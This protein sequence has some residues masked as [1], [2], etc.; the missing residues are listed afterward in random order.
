MD[1]SI[2]TTPGGRPYCRR[3][4]RSARG[5]VLGNQYERVAGKNLLLRWSGVRREH[6]V[7]FGCC[8]L[9][10]WTLSGDGSMTSCMAGQGERQESDLAGKN[11]RPN[12]V[13][14]TSEDNGPQLAC[15]GDP[16][17]VTPN[18]D[19]LAT[20]SIRFTRC[21]SNAPVCAPARTTLITGVWPT[22]LGASHMRSEVPL[23]EMMQLF[24]QYLRHAGYYCTN[25]QK[26]DY[27][28][29]PTA[30]P[31]D[32][33]GP[34]AHWK[35][36]APDQPFFAVFNIGTTHESQIRKRPHD[37]KLDPRSISVPPYHPDLPEVR[38]DWA[39]YYDKIEQM[40]QE[41]GEILRQLDQ[42][43]LLDST[44]V[45]YFGDHGS[46]MP[47]SKRWLYQGGLH[48][49]LLISL[50]PNFSALAAEGMQAGT[51]SDIPISFIDMAPTTLSLAGIEPPQWMTG[52]A[53]LGKYQRE[54]VRYQFGF[55]DRMDERVDCSRAVRDERFLYIRNWMPHQPQGQFL[56]YMFLTPTTQAWEKH[57]KE[58]KTNQAQSAFWLPK[59]THELYDLAADPHQIHNLFGQKE[60]EADQIRLSRVLAEWMV[61]SRDW[62]LTPESIMLADSR[63][64][65]PWETGKRLSEAMMR[66]RVAAADWASEHR[67]NETDPLAEAGRW[68]QSEDPVQRYWGAMGL[69]I[70]K[71]RNEIDGDLILEPQ[72]QDRE[73]M[74]RVVAAEFL[75]RAEARS[76]RNQG[77]DQLVAIALAA[78]EDSDAATIMLA[79]SACHSL[80]N[81]QAEGEDIAQR[82]SG[83]PITP[84]GTP[85]RYHPYLKD[86]KRIF[87]A[88]SDGI[89]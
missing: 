40:D 72:L 52:R 41:V 2:R 55:R 25:R 47:R 45:F 53:L 11:S 61:E 85:A 81:A 57:W 23:P 59:P 22:S 64:S 83:L 76:L 62:G 20:R 84:K 31:W 39:Q 82:L 73:P 19:Q 10:L 21:W 79:S 75:A 28:V 63:G 6:R 86:F 68:L 29:R 34:Q 48:V 3:A 44:I 70:R 7:L 88:W 15:Y 67:G 9:L 32:V 38:R 89:P 14:I 36:R 69:L 13:W 27:N 5:D 58:G 24:P 30:S 50:P 78:K 49:P 4:F 12:I 65:S 18:L 37:A 80:L 43:N 66:G 16:L 8:L 56:D 74:V 77:V 42:D 26:E 46:G 60:M 87:Q 1:R 35:Q 54:P 71:C 17:A 33:S 51:A